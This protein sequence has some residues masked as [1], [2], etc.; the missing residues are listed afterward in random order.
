M[1]GSRHR[2]EG[3]GVEGDLRFGE[4]SVACTAGVLP[5]GGVRSPVRA[6]G[7]RVP[8]FDVGRDAAVEPP[9]ALLWCMYLS[10]YALRSV[11]PLSTRSATDRHAAVEVRARHSTFESRHS[12][13]ACGTASN[14]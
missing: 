10:T 7:G 12:C 5:R 3:D 6:G 4:A 14:V 1:V 2:L 13:A 11:Q 8:V 9:A